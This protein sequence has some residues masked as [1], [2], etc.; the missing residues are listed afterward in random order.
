MGF[1]SNISLEELVN[2][3]EVQEVA[4]RQDND[5]RHVR[6]THQSE[7]IINIRA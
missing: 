2:N 1:L 5:K 4:D 7:P 3:Q 6:A